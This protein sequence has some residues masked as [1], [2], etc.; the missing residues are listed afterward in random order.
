MTNSRL[1]FFD[2]GIAVEVR[3]ARDFLES[4]IVFSCHSR[5]GSFFLQ[6]SDGS[7]VLK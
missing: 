2:V 7:D 5:Y 1:V 3:R 6:L 4:G